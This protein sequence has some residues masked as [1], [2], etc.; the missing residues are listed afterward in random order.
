M[1]RIWLTTLLA[2]GVLNASSITAPLLDVQNSRATIIAENLREGMSGVIV[3]KF[4]AAHSTIIANARVEKLNSANGRAIL[5]LSKYDGLR[6]N[7]LPSG[8][9]S[10]QPSDVAVLASD[11]ERALLIAPN[12]ETYDTVT[13]SISGIEWIHP[14]NYATYLSY[15][16]HP[17]PLKED[18]SRYCTANSIGLLYIHSADTL[19]TLD[20]KSFALLQTAPLLKKEKQSSTPFYS[21]IPTI[22]AAWWGEGSS[23]LESYEPYY[24]QLIALNNSKNKELYELYKAKFSE[25]SA[26]LRYFEIKE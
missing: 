22:R 6:Q 3:R 8:N 23:R 7:S 10:V 13:K 17:T 16:G 20:C 19:F 18:F 14:D 25:K 26:L 12:D 5:K 11:Y 2:W 1:M 9:W 21:R 15:E 24:L 4:D